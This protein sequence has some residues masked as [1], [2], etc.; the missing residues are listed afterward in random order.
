MGNGKKNKKR[1]IKKNTANNYK[2]TVKK[3]NLSKNKIN[4]I[5]DIFKERKDDKKFN[6]WKF[7][8]IIL[9]IILLILSFLQISD[10]L[11]KI[12]IEKNS[13]NENI[14]QKYLLLGDSLFYFY[15]EKEFLNG[16]NV[17]NSG[18]NGI[19]ALNMDKKLDDMVFKYNPTIVFILLGTNDIHNEYTPLESFNHLKKLIDD[20][21]EHNNISVN[22]ISLLPINTS[23]DEKIDSYIYKYRSNNKINEFNEYLKQFCEENNLNYINIHDI[24]LDEKNELKIDYT[25]DGLHLNDLGYFKFTMELLKY[26]N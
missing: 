25:T 20:I 7:S 5:E 17:I 18:I 11:K 21:K 9:L 4:D 12:N 3:E 14:E 2:K 22:V 16:Y 8:T 1:K 24:L 26:F 13:N 10:K 15:K 19:T 23:N 6:V